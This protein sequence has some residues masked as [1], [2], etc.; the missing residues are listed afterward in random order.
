MRKSHSAQQSFEM[1]MRRLR[2]M[3]I[4]ERVR[5]ALELQDRFSWLDPSNEDKENHG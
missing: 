4:E 2:Q 3:S 5:E 1:E